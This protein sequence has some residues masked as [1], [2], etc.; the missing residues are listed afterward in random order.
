[1]SA[2]RRPVVCSCGRPGCSAAVGDTGVSS[3]GPVEREAACLEA[4]SKLVPG[5][6]QDVARGSRAMAGSL[7]RPE[8]ARQRRL[9]RRRQ[10]QSTAAG[11]LR[12][13]PQM[14]AANLGRKHHGGWT[15]PGSQSQSVL[16]S[17]RERRED[18]QRHR[19]PLWT[20]AAQLPGS[21]HQPLTTSALQPKMLA[22]SGPEGQAASGARSAQG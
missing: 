3:A 10:L 18:A 17:F 15:E 2:V 16:A 5:G 14:S 8:M 9:H 20:R 12:L 21:S 22:R 19:A 6:A 11:L 7:G 4:I 1:M 13:P